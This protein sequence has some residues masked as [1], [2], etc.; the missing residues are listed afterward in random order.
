MNNGVPDDPWAKLNSQIARTDANWNRLNAKMDKVLKKTDDLRTSING[1][2]LTEEDKNDLRLWSWFNSLSLRSVSIICFT[3]V[4]VV[5]MVSFT[6]S[7]KY[8][9]GISIH[10]MVQEELNKQR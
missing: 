6:L 2:R 1:I 5:F 8:S 7:A 10:N 9:F 4:A 3:F